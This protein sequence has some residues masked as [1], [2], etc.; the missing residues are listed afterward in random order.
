[1]NRKIFVSVIGGVAYPVQATVPPGYEVEIV[2]FDDID[3]TGEFPSK[4]AFEHY[5]GTGLYEEKPGAQRALR[6][7]RP[8]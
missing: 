7:S 6:F 5:L 1:M 8:S 2:D 4:E 3:E